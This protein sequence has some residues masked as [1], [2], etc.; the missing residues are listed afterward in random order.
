MESEMVM[1][2]AEKNCS[3]VEIFFSKN[4]PQFSISNKYTYSPYWEIVLVYQ[5]IRIKIGGDIGFSVDVY[6]ENSEYPLWQYDRSVTDK[7][8][9]TDNNII[10][11]LNVLKKFLL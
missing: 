9:T 4:F 5:D 10:Y 1:G 3:I 6:I 7:M 2:W 8:K 11:Q